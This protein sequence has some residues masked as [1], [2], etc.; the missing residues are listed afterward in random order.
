IAISLTYSGGVVVRLVETRVHR[1]ALSFRLPPVTSVTISIMT[2]LNS[3]FLYS[4]HPPCFFTENASFEAVFIGFVTCDGYIFRLLGTPPA[5]DRD[6]VAGNSE[7]I[8]I[9]WCRIGISL[10]AYALLRGTDR[11]RLSCA[12]CSVKQSVAF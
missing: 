4:S 2:G 10:V 1:G 11:S 8:V 5:R 7:V 12:R 3:H 6:H 9:G